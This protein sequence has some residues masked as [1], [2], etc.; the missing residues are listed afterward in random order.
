MRWLTG[1]LFLRGEDMDIVLRIALGLIALS[2]GIILSLTKGQDDPL[3]WN[4]SGERIFWSIVAGF[5]VGFN[6]WGTG[7]L[8]MTAMLLGNTWYMFFPK[9]YGERVWYLVTIALGLLFW[10]LG[11]FNF[12]QFLINFY[13]LF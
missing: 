7:A 2:E 12:N 9:R 1:K 4:V 5:A 3:D 13:A 11:G 8:L 6:Y 10:V